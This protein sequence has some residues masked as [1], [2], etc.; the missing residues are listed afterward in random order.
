MRGRRSHG[1]YGIAHLPCLIRGA[2]AFGQG[3]SDEVELVLAAV[4]LGVDDSGLGL[5]DLVSGFVLSDAELLELL[6]ALPPRLS[7]L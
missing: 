6:P 7:V 1:N 4:V 5:S 2:D 3:Q